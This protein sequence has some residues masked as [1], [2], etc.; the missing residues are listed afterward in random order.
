[1]DEEKVF[2]QEVIQE[3][4]FPGEPEVIAPMAQ[5]NPIGTFTPPTVKEKSLP[6]KRTAVE[7]LSTA[8][9][10]RSRKILEEFELQQSG[11]LKIGDFKEGVSGDVRITPNGLTG[12]NIAG[13]VTFALDTD[14]NLALVGELRAGSTVTGQ[15]VV[16]NNRVIIDVDDGG[17]PSIIVS[18]GSNDRILIGYQSNG[19]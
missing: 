4:P 8:L 18:D 2:T 19:F 17:Q 12:R 3:T 6:K 14:G 16:G 9:N 10:T 11:G 15:V 7:L 1:M 13:L 5:P